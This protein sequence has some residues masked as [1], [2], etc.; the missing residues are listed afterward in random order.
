MVEKDAL[1]YDRETQNNKLKVQLD[2]FEEEW[3]FIVYSPKG[4][5]EL[6]SLPQLKM[7]IP[8]LS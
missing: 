3:Y 2:N 7:V 1:I 6:V 8:F 4:I 5:Y